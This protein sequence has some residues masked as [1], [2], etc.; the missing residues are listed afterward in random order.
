M[1]YEVFLRGAR[2]KCQNILLYDVAVLKTTFDFV[3]V[4]PPPGDPGGRFGL[5]FSWHRGFGA[6]SG[7]DLEVYTFLI[8][9]LALS[10]A[11]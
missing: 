8:L 5:Q 10:A 7:L 9:F 11:K 3:R 2:P 4:A 1:F 6:P